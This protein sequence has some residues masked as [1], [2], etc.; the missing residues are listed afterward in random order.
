LEIDTIGI[1]I[2][3][4]SAGNVIDNDSDKFV[5][6]GDTVEL[7]F[8]EA[9]FKVEANADLKAAI[10]SVLGDEGSNVSWSA[11]SK[12]L[13]FD[14]TATTQSSYQIS[15][16]DAAGNVDLLSITLDVI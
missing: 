10:E 16:E 13:S 15:F 2:K 9:V 4:A 14:V 8:F 6:Q 3:N 1:A 11:D 12:I 7:N 5:S